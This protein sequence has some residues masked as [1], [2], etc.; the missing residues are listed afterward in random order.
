MP[1]VVWFD[2]FLLNHFYCSCISCFTFSVVIVFSG[3]G[4]RI[5]QE[6]SYCVLISNNRNTW[7][8]IIHVADPT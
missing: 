4:E 3:E 2:V 8:F 6:R 7:K 5:V 1:N